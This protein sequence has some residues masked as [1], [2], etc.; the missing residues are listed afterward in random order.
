MAILERYRMAM[1][2]GLIRIAELLAEAETP[3]RVPEPA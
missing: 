2:P 1:K 3:E